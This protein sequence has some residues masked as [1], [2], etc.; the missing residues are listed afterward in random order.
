MQTNETNIVIL[1]LSIP[2]NFSLIREDTINF[3][4]EEG[5]P[6]QTEEQFT[7]AHNIMLERLK[8]MKS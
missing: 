3:C 6:Y 4:I 8:S 1:L 2:G 7:T 5:L